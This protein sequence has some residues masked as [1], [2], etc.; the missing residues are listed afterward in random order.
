MSVAAP[1]CCY[2]KHLHD[3]QKNKGFFCDAFPNGIPSGILEYKA[4]HRKPYKDDHGI[5][6]EI[7]DDLD[8]KEIMPL[9]DFI[10]EPY[11]PK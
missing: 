4:D 9:I 10:F 3:V 7:M 8:A 11:N 1:I 2:C 5:Q 6:F